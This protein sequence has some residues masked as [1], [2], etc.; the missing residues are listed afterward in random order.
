MHNKND[1][2]MTNSITNIADDA[3]LDEKSNLSGEFVENGVRLVNLTH[4]GKDWR[5]GSITA[6]WRNALTTLGM[7]PTPEALQEL[8]NQ[9]IWLSPTKNPPKMALVCGGQGAVWPHMGREI[10]DNLPAARDAMDQVAKHFKWDVL[11]IM[12]ET[13]LEKLGRTRWQFPYVF[14]LSYAQTC[15]LKSLGFKPDVYSG[16]SLGELV[17]L[18]LAGVYDMESACRL[19]DGRAVIVDDFEHSG[20]HDSGMMAVYAN[21]AKIEET[22]RTFPSLHIS[23][24]NTPTQFI[25][26]GP[27]DVLAEARRSLRK[28]K[29]PAI[30]LNVT[31]AFHH[32]HM[33]VLRDSAQEGLLAFDMKAPPYPVLSNVTA[34]VYPDDKQGIVDYI[35]DLDENTVRWVD[36]VRTMWNDFN[37]RNFVEVGPSDIIGGLTKDIEPNAHCTAVCRKGKELETMRRAVAELYAMGHISAKNAHVVPDDIE[38][39][40]DSKQGHVAAVKQDTAHMVNPP[41]VEDIIP[42]LMEETG[43]EHHKLTANMDLRHDLAMR[44][45]RFPIILH[46]LE[47]AFD[48]QINFEDLLEVTTIGDL[49]QVVAD[50]RNNKAHIKNKQNGHD[51]QQKSQNVDELPIV[52]KVQEDMQK[53]PYVFPLG[54]TAG[55]LP[56]FIAKR[57]FSIYADADLQDQQKAMPFVNEV[58]MLKSMYAGVG[59]GFSEFNCHGFDDVKFNNIVP[60]K[61]GITREGQIIVQAKEWQG[62]NSEILLAKASLDITDLTENGRKTQQKTKVS[63]GNVILAKKL[64]HMQSIWQEN[65][66]NLLDNGNIKEYLYPRKTFAQQCHSI[67]SWLP[68]CMAMLKKL[69]MPHDESFNIVSISRLRHADVLPDTGEISVLWNLS[70]SGQGYN[71]DAQIQVEKN[72]ILTVQNMHISNKI[73]SQDA[74]AS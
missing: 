21:E 25:L 24:F 63:E 40:P 44:S 45:S 31:M 70:S 18:C 73:R 50:F 9:G 46:K 19:F 54:L 48:I 57:N 66:Q 64:C 51:S 22:L 47:T 27:R 71:M 10:Y 6:N 32:P 23:N 58:M 67:Y 17:A 16:H 30:I 35:T 74:K 59:L 28:Q 34:G 4:A 12:D 62:A 8:Q 55:E 65:I 42:I 11:S 5:L 33:R 72:I 49:A 29:S 61:G 53:Y 56:A 15:Y 41:Y 36:C 2:S 7:N 52:R 37:V 38:A 20:N 60:C 26:S 13:D 3:P 39:T 69:A 1:T 14:L 43:F 68:L